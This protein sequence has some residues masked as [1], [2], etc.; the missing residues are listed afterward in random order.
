MPAFDGSVPWK[1]SAELPVGRPLA[2]SATVSLPT[3]ARP[4]PASNPPNVGNE[5]AQ[6]RPVAPAFAHGHAV[7]LPS[8]EQ[9]LA[10]R[11]ASLMHNEIGGWFRKS[12]PRFERLND[13]SP[14]VAV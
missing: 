3:L 12:L 4:L 2:V 11:R 8:P 13:A 9:K 7:A 6:P 5:L 14:L 10:N 1:K